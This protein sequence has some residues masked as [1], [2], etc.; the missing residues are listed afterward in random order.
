MIS[1]LAAYNKLQGLPMGKYVFSRIVCLMAPYF[2]T[3]KPRFVELKPGYGKITMKNRR[4]VRNHLKSVHAVAMCNLCELAGGTTLDVT[5]PPHLRWIPRGME[6]EYIKI[7]K[8]NLTGTCII[9]DKAIKGKGSLPVMVSVTD[10]SGTEVM[11]AVIDM[12]ITER[13]N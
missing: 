13:N 4:A 2:K 6:V 1:V 9:S 10:T 12:H 5:L 8:S 7:A 3:I 11:K